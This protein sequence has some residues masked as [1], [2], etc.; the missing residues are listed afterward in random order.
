MKEDY[1]KNK[2]LQLL[3]KHVQLEEAI[4]KVMQQIAPQEKTKP[5][6]GTGSRGK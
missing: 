5:S 6:K 3:E 1:W 2:Y 4:L